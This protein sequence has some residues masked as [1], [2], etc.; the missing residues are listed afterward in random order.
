MKSA[1]LTAGAAAG[2]A[3]SA[4]AALPAAMKKPGEDGL[5]HGREAEGM[6][7]RKLGRTNF[8][9][10]RLVFGCGAALSGGKAVRLLDRALEAGVNFYD[11][12]SNTYYRGAESSFAPFMKANRDAI[13]VSSKAPQKM[14]KGRKDGDP[15][16]V[17]QAR[18]IAD[19]WTKLLEASLKDLDTD[20]V[21]AYYIMACSDPSVVKAEEMYQAFLDAKAAGKVGHFGVSTHHNTTAVVEAMAETGWYDLVMVGITPAGWYDWNTRELAEGTPPMLEL[22]PVFEKARAAGIGLI[23]MKSARF[24]SNAGG[25]NDPTLFDSHYTEKHLNSGLDGF[26]RAYAYVL[27]NGMDVVNS[28]MQNFE[29]FEANVKAVRESDAVFA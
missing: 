6:T 19:M 1:A 5:I 28:D 7:Y 18:E 22:K 13:W 4:H 17:E 27:A 9:S 16:S 2:I 20:Y 29:H 23:G 26:Q 15:L 14:V 10:S 11:I 3:G 25:K 24:I 12:G 21:D 8:Y